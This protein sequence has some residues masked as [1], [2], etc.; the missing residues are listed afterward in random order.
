MAT[1][2]VDI[3]AVE[4]P[5][6]V[7]NLSRTRDHSYRSYFAQGVTRIPISALNE[8][9]DSYENIENV[10]DPLLVPNGGPIGIV[11]VEL[12]S[13]L[14]RPV[15]G[16]SIKFESDPT[17][18][19]APPLPP[20]PTSVLVAIP[21]T[22]GDTPYPGAYAPVLTASVSGVVP[23]DGVTWVIDSDN[24]YVEFPYGVPSSVK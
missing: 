21:A 9:W 4:R 13:I 17:Q 23:Y 7:E 1:T 10:P 24:S 19:P 8:V 20:S 2:S 3:P 16:S 6:Y 15:S 14:L 22:F 12:V 18:S 5:I 11:P